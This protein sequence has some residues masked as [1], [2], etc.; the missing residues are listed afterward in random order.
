MKAR[1][2][3]PEL[4]GPCV[5]LVDWLQMPGTT[6]ESMAKQGFGQYGCMRYVA[7]INLKKVKPCHQ[8]D[9]AERQLEFTL[10]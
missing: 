2:Y 1:K 5:Y 7:T 10:Q 9:I 6:G 4:C 8:E 3:N